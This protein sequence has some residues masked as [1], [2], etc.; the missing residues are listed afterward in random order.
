M[1][2]SPATSPPRRSGG[3]TEPSNGPPGHPAP[4]LRALLEP[5]SSASPGCYTEHD[6]LFTLVGL[7]T[8]TSSRNKRSFCCSWAPQG[9]GSCEPGTVDE[10]QVSVRISLWS[11]QRPNIDLPSIT[12][13]QPG[14]VPGE[15][16]TVSSRQVP[17]S[18]SW[19]RPPCSHGPPGLTPSPGWCPPP[20]FEAH[21]PSVSS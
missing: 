6:T 17:L 4:T 20:L 10:D 5:P 19:L 21:S 12:I 14:S 3:R 9:F 7:K 18:R 16:P 11:S 1:S 8:G 2:T 15:A 13:S